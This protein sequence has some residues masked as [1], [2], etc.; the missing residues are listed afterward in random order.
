MKRFLSSLVFALIAIGAS[1]LIAAAAN[2]DWSWSDLSSYLSVRDNRPVW[3]MAHTNAG[4]HLTDGQ[5]LWSGGQVYRFD[6]STS[7]NIT[8]DIR[9]A[10]IDRVDD[11]VSDN[12][13]TTIF[14]QDVVRLDNKFRIV[15]NKNGTFYNATDIVRGM[16]DSDEGISQIVGYK[17][18]WRLVTTKGRLFGWNGNTS[19]PYRISLPSAA[20]SIVTDELYNS[21]YRNFAIYSIKN[22]NAIVPM[23]I[24]PVNNG[25]WMLHLTYDQHNYSMS[26]KTGMGFY[27]KWYRVTD[28]GTFTDITNTLPTDYHAAMIGSNGKNVLIISSDLYNAQLRVTDGLSSP[29]A[30]SIA[31]DMWPTTDATWDGTSW[32]LIDNAKGIYRVVN[33]SVEYLGEARDYF[34]SASGDTN[35]HILIGGTISVLGN[36]NPTNP[37]TAKLVMVTE[38]GATPISSGTTGNTNTE[39]EQTD[40]G[41]GIRS[42]EW[43]TPNVS[44]IADGA[45]TVYGVGAT[46]SDDI[47]RID[48]YVNG[49]ILRTCSWNASSENRECTGTVWASSYP[50]NTNIF[51]NAKI[52][53]NTGRYTWTKGFSIW[54][55][56]STT[57]T[58]NS[59]SSNTD[60][61]SWVWLDPNISS[62]NADGTSVFYV[63]AND[64]DGI[65]RIVIVVNGKDRRTCT[66]N[67][68]GGNQ[69]CSYRLYGSD[70]DS[71]TSVYVNARIE[72]AKGNT[73][74]T[75]SKTITRTNDTS[76]NTNT[77]TDT[78]GKVSAWGWFD[79][80]NSLNRDTET[81]F[82]GQ[83]WAERGLDAIEVYV[84]NTLKR[85]CDFSTTYGNQDC[86]LTIRAN[87]YAG[88]TTLSVKVRAI[89]MNGVSTYGD[90]KSIYV[91]TSSS[92]SSTNTTNTSGEVKAWEW[93]DK[94]VTSITL[95]QTYTYHAG[96]WAEQ[97]VKSVTMYANGAAVYTCSYYS[98]SGNKDCWIRIDG[99]GFAV[100]ST[101]FVNALVRDVNGKEAWTTGKSVSITS[102]SATTATD[103][104]RST[105]SVSTNRD[106]GYTSTQLVT[107]TANATDA[108]GINRIEIY[109]NGKRVRVC[110]NT[111]VCAH[112][113]LPESTDKY[114]VY[115]ASIVDKLGNITSTDYKQ[116]ARIK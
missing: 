39:H 10:G 37:L 98:M 114:L 104:N 16:L 101:I 46:D 90:A 21:N 74:W 6:G 49:S 52:T 20:Q 105:I 96:A 53:D 89:D 59:N 23:T 82:H 41:T 5:N 31:S 60:S 30:V 24:Q 14:L 12:A 7:V 67:A 68:A 85:T 11:I 44:T 50:A 34:T 33:S 13:D 83:A 43:L 35:G 79:S 115:S 32:M 40:T 92:N 102:G 69:K 36:P 97:G 19:A 106:S 110:S 91:N 73:R 45:Q 9:N 2:A 1:P 22:R 17:G 88:G 58:N 99:R 51:V 28:G 103:T 8:T 42:W 3:A 29:T 64:A 65:N 76:T 15:V 4:W 70:Y 71:G 48:L 113:T 87:D 107:L 75:D 84:N 100:G 86:T 61:T 18:S 63:E 66:Y 26:G 56:T 54:H 38:T 78:S 80:T 25:E 77:N 109:V 95:D 94:D 116:I 93:T 112:T 57:N 47:V 27:H 108:D 81:V 62:F 72:D 55:G 111:T